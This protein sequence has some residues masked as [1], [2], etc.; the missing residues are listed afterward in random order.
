MAYIGIF[1]TFSI[2]KHFQVQKQVLYD[3]LKVEENFHFN[4]VCFSLRKLNTKSLQRRNS[5]KTLDT[6]SFY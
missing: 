3:F 5:A 4:K 1:N 2:S 6:F